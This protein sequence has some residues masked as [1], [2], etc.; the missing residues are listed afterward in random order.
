MLTYN[1]MGLIDRSR[2]AEKRMQAAVSAGTWEGLL[3][4]IVSCFLRKP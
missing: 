1:V 3:E 2:N 4:F